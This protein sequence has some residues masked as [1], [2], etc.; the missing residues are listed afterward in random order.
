MMNQDVAKRPQKT[1]ERP[2]EMLGG[3]RCRY[4]D[5]VN[6]AILFGLVMSTVLSTSHMG[7]HAAT[8]AEVEPRT[9][10]RCPNSPIDNVSLPVGAVGHSGRASGVT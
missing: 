1:L 3:R 10:E 9:R 7:N 5:N 2:G 4:S 8:C 6:G